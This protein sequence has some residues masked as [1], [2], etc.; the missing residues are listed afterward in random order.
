MTSPKSIK[1]FRQHITMKK[2]IS[3]QYTTAFKKISIWYHSCLSMVQEYQKNIALRS[4]TF[5]LLAR[6]WPQSSSPKVPGEQK[7]S[8]V[9]TN[10]AYSRGPPPPARGV[11]DCCGRF[12][13]R[14]ASPWHSSRAR[15]GPATFGQ[16]LWPNVSNPAYVVTPTST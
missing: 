7:F 8:G 1:P 6:Q 9:Q 12:G 13:R 11:N 10:V 5:L 14:R 16:S 4:V 2:I 3:K 15:F